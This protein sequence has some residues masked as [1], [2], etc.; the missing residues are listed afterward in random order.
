MDPLTSNVIYVD[1]RAARDRYETSGTLTRPD[2]SIDTAESPESLEAEVEV[3]DVQLN[4]STL[5]SVFSK[6]RFRYMSLVA[7]S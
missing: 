4:L 7:E 1:K 2:V 3:N 6:G 5:L